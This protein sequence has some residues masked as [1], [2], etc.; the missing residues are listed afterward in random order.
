MGLGGGGPFALPVFRGGRG[1]GGFTV[2]RLAENCDLSASELPLR[3]LVRLADARE[4]Q[5]RSMLDVSS[6]LKASVATVWLRGLRS[7]GWGAMLGGLATVGSLAW[8]GEGQ[9]RSKDLS[10]TDS[11]RKDVTS[12]RAESTDQS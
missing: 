8:S 12:Q 4:S 1:G 11:C 5:L 7:S 2:S 9:G 10:V 6:L 3:L